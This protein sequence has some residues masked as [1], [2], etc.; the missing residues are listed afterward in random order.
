[1][2]GDM[3][4]YRLENILTQEIP[5]GLLMEIAYHW[6]ANDNLLLDPRSSGSRHLDHASEWEVPMGH[7]GSVNPPH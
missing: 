2:G 7:S 3:A 1:M 6:Q 4:Q 5:D